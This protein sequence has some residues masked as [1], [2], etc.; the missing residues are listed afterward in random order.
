ML[1]NLHRWKKVFFIYDVIVKQKIYKRPTDYYLA[2][3]A[4]GPSLP[5]WY[6]CNAGSAGVVEGTVTVMDAGDLESGFSAR[7]RGHPEGPESCQ[8]DV[9]RPSQPGRDHRRGSPHYS[10]FG[11]SKSWSQVFPGGIRQALR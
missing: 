5:L 4:L 2:E 8:P 7:V 3:V 9:R 11:L 1:R 6:P 10:Y